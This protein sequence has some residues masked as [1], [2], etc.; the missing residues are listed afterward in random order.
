MLK[1]GTDVRVQV[2]NDDA[3]AQGGYRARRAWGQDVWKAEKDKERANKVAQQ[4]RRAAALTAELAAQSEKKTAAV[5]DQPPGLDE[6]A[7]HIEAPNMGAGGSHPQATMMPDPWATF[8]CPSA[9]DNQATTRVPPETDNHVPA[10]RRPFASR[11]GFRGAQPRSAV[12]TPSTHPRGRNVT[13]GEMQ[14]KQPAEQELRLR[15]KKEE[16]WELFQKQ[17]NF[18]RKTREEFERK[19]SEKVLGGI[20]WNSKD[21]QEKDLQKW[22]NELQKVAD[23]EERKLEA[24]ELKRMGEEDAHSRSR[25]A[26]DKIFQQPIPSLFSG[27][28]WSEC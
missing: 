18:V 8:S 23:L 24:R 21:E 14:L 5:C 13:I 12:R 26:W 25:Q 15:R 11:G 27:K 17:P 1:I 4:V 28:T 9:S 10:S 7:G 16:A 2:V 3:R 6:L 22:L 19:F 20:Y